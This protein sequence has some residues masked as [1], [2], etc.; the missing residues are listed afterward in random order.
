[1]DRIQKEA[2]QNFIAGDSFAFKLIY[3][4]QIDGL[5]D[6][7]C[8]YTPDHALIKDCIQDL[9]VE[10]NHYRSS[11]SP[12]VNVKAYLF[13]SLRRKLFNQIQKSP[14]TVDIEDVR[15]TPFFSIDTNA[16][17]RIIEK[18][19]SNELVRRLNL[20]LKK[21]TSKQ[22]EV[23]YLKFNAELSYDEIAKA[24]QISVPTCR[25]LV[26]RAIKQ[27]RIKMESSSMLVLFG[28]F[29]SR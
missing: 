2:W 10:L 20:E 6:Y 5:F 11:L 24:M 22:Q 15:F 29:F 14:N 8:R 12:E 13:T 3:E 19:Q 7:G 16:E 17:I 25:T 4:N 21:L 9:F 23:L 27:L 1:M 18:E 28:I 26:Y